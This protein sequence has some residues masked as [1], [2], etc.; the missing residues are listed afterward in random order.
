MF[1]FFQYFTRPLTDGEIIGTALFIYNVGGLAA[2]GYSWDGRQ[3]N[4]GSRFFCAVNAGDSSE[5]CANCLTTFRKA[6]GKRA[7][8]LLKRRWVE[9][10]LFLGLLTPEDVRG[11][12][13]AKFYSTKVK[14]FYYLNDK[15][16]FQ[17][18]DGVFKLRY[19]QETVD[20]FLVVNHADFGQL[21]VQDLI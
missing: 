1:P 16:D 8:G 9:G 12:V 17:E 13:P 19:D 7:N 20:H 2:T 3:L 15:N 21:S 11:L 18:Q 4:E 10:A 5:Y 14:E 6:N